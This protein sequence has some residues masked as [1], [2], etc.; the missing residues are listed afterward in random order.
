MIVGIDLGTTHSLISV[1]QENQAVL[2]PNAL[3]E[4]L[5]PSA[6]GIGEEGHVLVGRAAHDYWLTRPESCA[7]IFKR[8]MGSDRQY[9][10]GQR[11][12]RPEELSALVLKSLKA[13]AEHYLHESVSEAIITVPAY[14][15]NVQ[16]TA[17]RQAGELAGLTVKRLINEPTAAALSYGLQEAPNESTFMVVDLGGGTFDVAILERFD[18]LMEVRASTGDNF[19]GGEDFVDIILDMVRRQ[20]P[21]L[22]YDGS[23]T[24]Q[25]R[26]WREAERVKRVLGSGE[27]A[28]FALEWETASYRHTIHAAAFEKACEPLLQRIRRPIERALRDAK[29]DASTIGEVV[30][31]GGATRMPMVRRLVAKMFGRIPAMH[32]NPDEVIARGA[33]V[34]AGLAARDQVL[35]EI[36]MVDVCPYS[37]GT[38]ITRQCNGVRQHG[39]F[40]PIIE[41]NTPVPVSRES[42]YQTGHDYQQAVAIDVY[43]GEARLVKDNIL[44]G[45]LEIPIPPRA[46]GEI[47]MTVRFTY[48]VSGILECEV[49]IPSTGVVE[50]LVLQG[51]AHSLTPSQVAAR[52]QELAT[53]KIHPRNQQ[54]NITTL[55]RA[56]RLHEELTGSD[57]RTLADQILAMEAALESQETESIDQAR[58]MLEACMNRLERNYLY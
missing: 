49:T 37:L 18:D 29:L 58:K 48:D 57:R 52:L 3:G 27:D 38:S 40:D 9:R 26:L 23:S 43:Q 5:T 20:W 41:R 28:E 55:A 31:A 13:D 19:L 36:V 47:T 15:S 39:C 35:R 6:V 54:A 12:F 30:L 11:S 1:W 2:I 45:T 56:D 16:R 50:R 14:F 10:L 44:L 34:M 22:P 33:A 8:H 4:V 46:A 51:N 17:T 25:G 21:N 42:Q 32:L 7:T 53:L 24:L